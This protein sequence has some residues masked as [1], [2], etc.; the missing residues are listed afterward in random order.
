MEV[1]DERMERLANSLS[2]IPYRRMTLYTGRAHPELA[3]AI[4]VELG[5]P[6]GSITISD[7]EN[8]EF[9]IRIERTVRGADVFYIQPLCQPVHEHLAELCFALDAFKRASA[10]KVH[11]IL[12][13]FCYGKDDRK[14]DGRVPITAKEV[15][16]QV[17]RAAMLH[18]MSPDC[19]PN[20]VVLDF[21][22][23]QVQGFFG[24]NCDHINALDV[25][26]EWIDTLRPAGIE[27]SD[28]FTIVAPETDNAARARQ[29]A[30]RMTK[31]RKE[32]EGGEVPI[33]IIDVRSGGDKVNSMTLVGDVSGKIAVI[34]ETALD[35]AEAARIERI[36]PFLRQHG[37]KDVVAVATHPVLPGDSI[38]HIVRSG[39]TALGVCDTIPIPPE[40]RIPQVHV[41]SVARLLAKII[42]KIWDHRPISD[43]IF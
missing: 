8:S 28:A 9:A 6:L 41:I 42:D 27:P 21:Q 36:A 15:A 5:C 13:F 34:V 35:T 25:T 24:V 19:L 2:R 39:I 32:G 33:A 17:E 18:N 37:A 11:I 38:M 12:P 22:H 26:A 31:K 7:R 43:D 1:L 23:P 29:I 16:Q 30:K 4:S 40:K 10:R 14:S 3:A 20:V